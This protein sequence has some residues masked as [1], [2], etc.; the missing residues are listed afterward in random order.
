MID[1]LKLEKTAIF[2]DKDEN[3]NRYLSQF[4]K[5]YKN[6]F[7]PDVIN[8]GCQRC[9]EDYYVRLIKHLSIM[10]N[11]ENIKSEFVLKAKY[12]GIPESFGSQKFI[13]NS[14]ITEE[15][16]I[17]LL[18]NHKRGKDLF[19]KLPDNVDDLLN[20]SVDDSVDTTEKLSKKERVEL[21]KIASELELNPKDYDNKLEIA[22][23]IINKRNL[24]KIVLIGSETQPLEFELN[25]GTIVQLRDVVAEANKVSE[26]STEDWNKLPSEEIEE[27]IQGVI[28]TL[29]LKE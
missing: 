13:T 8:A 2:T 29:D 12:N 10:G 6:T 22:E 9:L 3:G 26:L 23:A 4:L 28:D 21:N 27:K 5:D 16:A 17:T 19:E 15:A 14:N 24:A 20:D 1:W 11:I 18:K 25:D 7:D